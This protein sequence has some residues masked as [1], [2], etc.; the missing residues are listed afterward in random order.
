V[1][2]ST[3][4]SLNGAYSFVP[5]V[6]PIQTTANFNNGLTDFTIWDVA[7]GGTSVLEGDFNGAGLQVQTRLQTGV[8]LGELSGSFL[9]TG[10]DADAQAAFGNDGGTINQVFSIMNNSGLN[11][12]C[13][14][15][16]VCASVT[17]GL[18]NDWKTFEANP[19]ST[20][21]R[22]PEPHA[23]ALLLLAAVPV[24]ARLRRR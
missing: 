18:A 9:I 21:V 1:I 15:T 7:G 24:A 16:V 20:L 17:T 4:L 8:I 12:L 22:L 5:P 23:A 2:F 11:N 3:Q 14:K 13:N 6:N 10:G 19:T